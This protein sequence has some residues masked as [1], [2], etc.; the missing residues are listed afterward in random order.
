[1]KFKTGDKFVIEI[2]ETMEAAALG[3]DIYRIKGF[4]SLVFD[5]SGLDKLRQ[6]PKDWDQGKD[7]EIKVG[8]VVK[9]ENGYEFVVTL[10]SGGTHLFGITAKGDT[11]TAVHISKCTKTGKHIDIQSILNRIN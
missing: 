1:M 4:N 2:A 5:E 6:L 9:V 8:D 11:Y 7:K 10:I 3:K